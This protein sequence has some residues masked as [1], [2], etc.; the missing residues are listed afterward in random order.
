RTLSDDRGRFSL[1]DLEQGKAQI[2]SVTQGFMTTRLADVTTGS[3]NVVIV[4]EKG[5]S[6]TGSVR[7]ENG[8]VVSGATVELTPK[9]A[10]D[11]WAKRG[12]LQVITDEKGSHLLQGLEPG[13]YDAVASTTEMFSDVQKEIEILAGKETPLDFVLKKGVRI[14]GRVLAETHADDQPVAGANLKCQLSH[15]G[16]TRSATSSAIGEFEFERVPSGLATVN[17][18]APSGYIPK[19]DSRQVVVGDEDVTDLEFRVLLGGK[20]SGIVLGPEGSGISGARVE[21]KKSG[22]LGMGF[23]HPES[24][25]DATG[26]Y[27]IDGLE[28]GQ[29]YVLHGSATGYAPAKSEPFA[30]KKGEERHDFNLVF[31]L[32]GSISGKVTDAS[33]EP[34]EGIAVRAGSTIF[35]M[36][37]VGAGISK[38]NE[39]GFYRIE[40]VP[41]G[42]VT[43]M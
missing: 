31:A 27:L 29:D 38:T 43:V 26:F 25:S 1:D 28:E 15:Y 37:R 13:T 39:L 24:V 41:E 7:L 19:S 3:E 32:G 21:I 34:L 35:E 42:Q 6:L 18:N 23:N 9:T 10:L 8:E 5:G 22:F 36:D 16:M 12:N 17:L 20:I 33:G 11:D 14:S 40:H 4:L 2:R 30:L